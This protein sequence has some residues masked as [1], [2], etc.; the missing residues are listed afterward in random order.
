MVRRNSMAPRVDILPKTLHIREPYDELSIPV[1]AALSG[2]VFQERLDRLVLAMWVQDI[3]DGDGRDS[4]SSEMRK[5]L[6]LGA[7]SMIFRSTS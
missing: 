7:L 4:Q 5:S 2:L 3:M 1:G 6:T